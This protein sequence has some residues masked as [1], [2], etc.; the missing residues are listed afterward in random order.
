MDVGCQQ[1]LKGLAHLHRQGVAALLAVAA[2]SL[3][4]DHLPHGFHF[5]GEGRAAVN[6]VNGMHFVMVLAVQSSAKTTSATAK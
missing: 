1:L 2:Q 4:D 3:L 5:W 6:H